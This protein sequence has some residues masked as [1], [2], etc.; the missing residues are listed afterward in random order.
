M[1]SVLFWMEH[2]T[3]IPTSTW[4]SFGIQSLSSLDF[5]LRL[6]CILSTAMASAHQLEH[7]DHHHVK[8][9]LW[10]Q[11]VDAPLSTAVSRTAPPADV[12]QLHVTR[13]STTQCHIG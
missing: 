11:L 9:P 1:L 2:G 7:P 5:L 3:L 6:F 10:R 4:S 8:G 13:V 12:P